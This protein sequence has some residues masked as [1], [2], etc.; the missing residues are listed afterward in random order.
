VDRVGLSASNASHTL[1][2]ELGHVLLDVPGHPDDYGLDTPTLLMDSD[3]ANASSFGPRRLRIED[4]ERMW[5]QSGPR[6][7]V[8]LLRPWPFQPLSK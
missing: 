5:Q 6:A 2:H 1:A 3:A 7:P 4:C 8:A